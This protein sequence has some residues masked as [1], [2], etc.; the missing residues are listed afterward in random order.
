MASTKAV[1][2]SMFAEGDIGVTPPLGVYDP[3]GLIATKDM[4]RFEIMEI[5]HGRAAMLGFLHVILIHA[6]YRLPGY[7]SIE[8]DLKFAV[9]PAGCFASLEA[10]P[11]AGWLQIMLTTCMLE[12]G[13]FGYN[14]QTVEADPGDI[15]GEKWVR[16]D[17]P[18][19]KTY[20]LNI[21]RQ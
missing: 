11:T 7:L 12:T 9:V 14:A 4:R 13:Y 2:A 5:K 21:E 17:D 1:S 3:L 6:G 18:A 16:Y 20:K 19:V 8:Q 10:L 15:G